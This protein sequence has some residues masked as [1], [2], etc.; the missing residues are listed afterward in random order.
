MKPPRPPLITGLTVILVGD[1]VAQPRARHIAGQRRPVSTASPKAK[2]YATAL[3]RVARAAVANLGGADAVKAA[4]ASHA[5]ALSISWTF[6]S[7]HD[8]RW[9]RPH[10]A[11]PDIDNICKLLCDRLMLA[12]ALGGDDARVATVTM[13]KVWA[14]IGSMAVT[15]T[16]I[17]CPAGAL[18]SAK[19]PAWLISR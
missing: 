6:S 12:G 9:G 18:S 3:E 15:V 1:P 17:S 16:P 4:F 14:R 8:Q 2:R 7:Q 5:L 13:T 19:T 11:K 10:T